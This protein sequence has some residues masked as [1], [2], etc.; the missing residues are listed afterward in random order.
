MSSVRR[1]LARGNIPGMEM[2]HPLK[3][4]SFPLNVTATENRCEGESEELRHIFHAPRTFILLM[5]SKSDTPKR[6]SLV[7]H[8]VGMQPGFQ[9]DAAT[10][11]VANQCN[12]TMLM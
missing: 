12:V 3:T 6:E 10:S 11:L 4:T 7:K 1:W 9:K 5:F 2:I 8:D